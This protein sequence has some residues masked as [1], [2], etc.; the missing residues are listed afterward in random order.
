MPRQHAECWCPKNLGKEKK[1][2]PKKQIKNLLRWLWKIS[3]MSRL[4]CQKRDCHVRKWLELNSR[5][6][7][8]NLAGLGHRV[9][10][11]NHSTKIKYFFDRCKRRQTVMKSNVHLHLRFQEQTAAKHYFANMPNQWSGSISST[12]SFLG[13]SEFFSALA[14]LHPSAPRR[15]NERFW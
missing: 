13:C 6:E 2:T 8:E 14:R 5:N 11:L 12:V 15:P 7:H 4:P 3:G 10:A 1:K 9:V